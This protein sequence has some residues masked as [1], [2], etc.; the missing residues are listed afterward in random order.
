M[1]L[2]IVLAGGD[3]DVRRVALAL[4]PVLEHGLLQ[5]FHF[6]LLPLALL[7]PTLLLWFTE[8][9]LQGEFAGCLINLP[10]KGQVSFQ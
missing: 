7:Q 2:T 4:D 3:G 6:L 9:L 5:F 10:L 8:V 1:S